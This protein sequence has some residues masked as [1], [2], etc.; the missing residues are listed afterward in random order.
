MLSCF[1]CTM[2]FRFEDTP[3]YIILH[4]VAE[5]IRSAVDWVKQLVFAIDEWVMLYSGFIETRDTATSSSNT[6]VVSV[7]PAVVFYENR[8]SR[9]LATYSSLTVSEWNSNISSNFYDRQKYKTT[10]E[11]YNNVLET[12]WKTRVLM[13]TTPRGNVLMYF[14]PYKMGF[15]Y[16]ADH[17]VPYTILNAIAMRYVVVYRCRDFFTDEFVVPETHPSPLLDLRR[18]EDK[19]KTSPAQTGENGKE[20]K[21]IINDA[22]APF[23][24]LKSYNK[25]ASFSTAVATNTNTNTNTTLGGGVGGGNEPT[26]KPAEKLQLMNAFVYL[27]KICNYSII[28]KKPKQHV[29]NGFSTRFDG[30]KKIS[31]SE[32]KQKQK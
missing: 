15:A 9:F 12:Q 22:S 4:F 27:G 21:N 25:T 16:Y 14:D 1:Y 29:L 2:V 19:K 18:A 10:L 26:T 32:F 31:W 13:E 24:K 20:T 28:Q 7:D 11:E 8:K 30:G 17:H 23:A 5:L 3:Q 6:A